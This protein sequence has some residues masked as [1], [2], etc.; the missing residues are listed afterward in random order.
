MTPDA[1]D[2]PSW[3]DRNT[4]HPP[5]TDI[6]EQPLRASAGSTVVVRAP[7]TDDWRRPRLKETSRAEPTPDIR[8]AT[9]FG[10]Q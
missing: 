2:H 9:R 3:W 5:P 10:P 7:T 6:G 4:T 8:F 1:D